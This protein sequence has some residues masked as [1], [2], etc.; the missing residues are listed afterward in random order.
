MQWH[1]AEF[2]ARAAH[3]QTMFVNCFDRII[4]TRAGVRGK[5]KIIVRS[6]IQAC[7]FGAGESVWQ[8]FFF[9]REQIL[10][11]RNE[12]T[13]FHLSHTQIANSLERP[14]PISRDAI[15]ECDFCTWHTANRPIETITN[16]SIHI[17]Q[18]ELLETVIKWHITLKICR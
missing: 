12:L 15:F 11:Y 1:C 18:I 10:K 5:S 3:S 8:F 6:Q 13:L 14:T 16:P 2:G 4:G 17:S 7:R 9:R